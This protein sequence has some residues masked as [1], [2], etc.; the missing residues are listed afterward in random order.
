[1]KDMLEDIT[2]FKQLSKNYELQ[3]TGGP[4]CKKPEQKCAKPMK[5]VNA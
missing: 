3:V 2:G 5:Y 4:P 1:M